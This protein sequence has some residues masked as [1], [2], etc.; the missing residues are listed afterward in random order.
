M[1]KRIE[2]TKILFLDIETVP[3]TDNYD[4]LDDNFKRLWEKK[5]QYFRDEE[6]TP[7]DV[8]QRAGIYAEFGKIICISIGYISDNETK[9]FRLKSFSGDNEEQILADFFDLLD[10]H[11][12]IGENYLCAHNGKEFDFPFIARRA[13]VN[14]VELPKMLNIAGKRPWETKHLLDTMEMW[15]FGDYKHFT[16]LDLLTAVFNIPTPKDDIDGSQ[17]ADV[18]Y[19]E[20]NL[21]RIVTYCEKDVIAIARLYLKYKNEETITDENIIYS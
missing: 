13:L 10:T 15:K 16:S 2:N 18:Y 17:I 20:N 11:Y 12:K 7:S 8:Y 5:S 1:F 21:E 19:K 9:T 14:G 6:Q 4:S 3:N